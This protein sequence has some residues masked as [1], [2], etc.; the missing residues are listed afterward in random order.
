MMTYTS[1]LTQF[2]ALAPTSSEYSKWGSESLLKSRLFKD[3][4]DI[5]LGDKS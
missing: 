4:D 3:D 5:V 1:D 2:G